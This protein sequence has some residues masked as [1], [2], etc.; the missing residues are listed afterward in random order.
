VQIKNSSKII[1]TVVTIYRS[2][3]ST[4]ENDLLL[5]DMINWLNKMFPSTLLVMGDFNLP[6]INWTTWTAKGSTNSYENNFLSCLRDNLFLQY[7]HC[8]TRAR[9]TDTA[10]ILDLVLSN[11]D[12]VSEISNL[13]PLGKSDH[14]VLCF[15]CSLMCNKDVSS[16]KLNLDK[17]DYRGFR[18]FLNRD[19]NT[20]FT[21]LEGN[22]NKVWNKFKAILSE[23]VNRFVPVVLN[24]WKKSLVGVDPCQRMSE[25]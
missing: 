10:N 14:S 22:V 15:N 19:W 5:I 2:P 18:A 24:N 4:V 20:D 13:S 7:V 17:G 1:L 9:G 11:E 16:T 23:G 3:N 8:P 21:E 25:K 12:F 6:G